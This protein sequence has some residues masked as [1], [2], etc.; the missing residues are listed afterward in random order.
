MKKVLIVVSYLSG[1]GAEHVARKNLQCLLNSPDFQAG[2][3]TCDAESAKK[4]PTESWILQDFKKLRS[5]LAQGS[6]VLGYQP[7][8]CIAVDCLHRF[9]PDIVHI[10]DF[11]PMTPSVWKAIREYKAES[12]CKVILTH[13]TYS[14]I[15][16][17]D[18]LYDYAADELCEACIGK[19]DMTIIRRKCSGKQTTACA[20]Y[21]QKKRFASY[22]NGLIDLHISPSS[23]LKQKLLQADKNLSVQVVYNPCIDEIMP[24]STQKK[25]DTIVYFGRISREKNIVNFAKLFAQIPSNYRLLVV[26]DGRL[27]AEM[28]ETAFNAQDEKIR[29][30]D[31]FL[32][33]EELYRTISSAQYFILPSVWYENSPVSIVEAINWSLIPLV[34]NIGGMDELIRLFGVGRTFGPK[35]ED[36]IRSMILNLGG[37][38]E[39][40]KLE[41]ARAQLRNFTAAAYSEKICGIYRNL[42]K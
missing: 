27:A 17:N 9:H 24:V 11:I 10:H 5:K 41:D 42:M 35:D 33:T 15:C 20:K 21:L 3:L 26:G 30:L 1:G 8:Y 31:R 36:A 18:S 29:F 7:N 22:W 38:G 32:P 12:G 37:A 4:Y 40:E 13:H 2:L 16:T 19:F 14:Y 34:S 25:A 28:A 23:F 6:A 39:T